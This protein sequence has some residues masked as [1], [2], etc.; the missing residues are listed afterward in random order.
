MAHEVVPVRKILVANSPLSCM[1][2]VKLEV[3]GRRACV[4]GSMYFDRRHAMLGSVA[5]VGVMVAKPF[6]MMVVA[7]LL[8]PALGIGLFVLMQSQ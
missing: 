4:V 8:G 3:E 7:T 6:I 5:G 1:L 2:I